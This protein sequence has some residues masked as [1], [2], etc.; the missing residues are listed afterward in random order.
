MDRLHE[1][2]CSHHPALTIFYPLAVTRYDHVFITSDI[3]F[4]RAISEPLRLRTASPGS[5]ARQSRLRQLL[6]L[7][8]LSVVFTTAGFFI[9]AAPAFAT[10]ISLMSL[11][12]DAESLA[13]FKTTDEKT[14]AIDQHINNHPLS[15]K[16]RANPEFTESRPHLRMPPNVRQHSLTSGTLLGPNRIPVPPL[17]FARE[18]DEFVSITYLGTDLC[19]HVG[20][21]H[22]GMLATMVDEGL[23]RCC[24]AALPNRIGVTASLTINYRSPAKAGSYV[25]LKAKTTKVEGRKAWVEGRIET[26]GEGEEPGKVLVEATGLFVEPKYA[27]NLAKIVN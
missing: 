25:V 17:A 12:T 7:S 6:T 8:A 13:A 16:L 23:A 3:R 4:S 15:Q 2:L 21:V 9:A 14:A 10:A 1:H 19:G 26:L 20:I 24:F 18:G 11:P 27:A 5:T 22:G